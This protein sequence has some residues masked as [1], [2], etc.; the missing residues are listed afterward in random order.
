MTYVNKC[1]LDYQSC[2]TGQKIEVAHDGKCTEDEGF[3]NDDDD[4]E[5]ED[6]DEDDEGSSNST[7]DA[8]TEGDNSTAATIPCKLACPKILDP[9]CLNGEREFGNECIMNSTVCLEKISV[10]SV[11]KG[12]CEKSRKEE[13]KEDCPKGCPRI[14]SPVCAN[15]GL[16]YNNECVFRQIVCENKLKDVH[17]VKCKEEGGGEE[18]K[19]VG[20]EEPDPTCSREIDPVCGS[21]GKTYNNR[22]LM[23][24]A[25]RCRKGLNLKHDGPCEREER[26]K[27]MTKGKTT[28][29]ASIINQTTKSVHIPCL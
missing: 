10:D 2:S 27:A 28:I 5:E 3:V 24:G 8:K 21:D 25:I 17:I 13:S 22:C 14:M 29:R 4:E 15:N 23:N 16:T 12:T 11:R 18:D 26:G 6:Y 9:V 1:K 7:A 19:D 20:C